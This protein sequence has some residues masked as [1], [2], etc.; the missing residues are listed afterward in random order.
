MKI[1]KTAQ[2]E[3]VISSIKYRFR[4]SIYVD[5]FVE[6]IN[7]DEARA[8]ARNQIQEYSNEIP[9]SYVGGVAKFKDYGLEMDKEI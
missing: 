6:G 7:E 4:G 2:F 3:N 8:K 5:L 1:I 9:N